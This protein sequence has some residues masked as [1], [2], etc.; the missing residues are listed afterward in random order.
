MAVPEALA[1]RDAI[2][3]PSGTYMAV[4]ARDAR[5]SGRTSPTRMVSSAPPPVQR[6]GRRP[7]VAGHARVCGP[8]TDSSGGCPGRSQALRH[9][10]GRRLAGGRCR[11]GP[12]P[13][14]DGE[15]EA[16]R[17]QG[18]QPSGGKRHVVGAQP[19]AEQAPSICREGRPNLV[20]EEHPAKEDRAGA[21]PEEVG[22][23][24]GRGGHCRDPVEAVDHAKQRELC[25]IIRKG[26]IEQG[27]TA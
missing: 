2:R 25:Q 9:A 7:A 13:L 8:S 19:D 11:P 21:A 20:A 5:G 1:V 10:H 26:Q 16:G 22:R 24:T 3:E 23:Q 15:D 12:L 14:P 4:L 6:Q 17:A 18:Q 27:Q